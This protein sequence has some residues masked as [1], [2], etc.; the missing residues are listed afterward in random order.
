MIGPNGYNCVEKK[1]HFLPYKIFKHM[2]K[3]LILIFLALLSFRVVAQNGY[4]QDFKKKWKNAADYTI[5]LAESMPEEFYDFKPTAD[6][7]TFKEQLLHMVTNMNWL[8]SAYLGGEKID[9]DLKST[10]YSKEEIIL[11][12]KNGY[13]LALQAVNNFKSESLEENVDFFAGEMNK[14]QILTL[15]ND[16]ST[17]HRGQLIVYLRLK[18]IKPPRY[19]GW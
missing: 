1:L 13:D 14:R 9:S 4:I 6:Q 12:L 3:G 17:H 16:H 7:Q 19:R 18:G 2:K 5:E 10:D 15:M 8:S 11:I